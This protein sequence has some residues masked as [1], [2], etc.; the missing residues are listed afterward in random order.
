MTLQSFGASPAGHDDRIIYLLPGKD[1]DLGYIAK[2][3]RHFGYKIEI[4]DDLSGYGNIV[5]P[6]I[7]IVYSDLSG[8]DIERLTP[9][10]QNTHGGLIVISPRDD[11]DARLAAV[12]LGASGYFTDTSDILKIIEK[13]EQY[14]SRRAAMPAWRVLVV[15]DNAI[16]AELYGN[17]LKQAGMNIAI[18]TNTRAAI[19]F[20]GDN[21]V[22]II[23]ID[24]L[25]PDCNGDELAALIRQQDRYISLPLVF[26]SAREDIEEMLIGRDLGIDE[27]LKKPFSPERLVSVIASRALRAAELRSYMVRDSFTGLLNHAYFLEQ[28]DLELMNARRHGKQTAYAII[29]ID[30]FK[31]V[32]DTYGHS[33]GDQVLK[34]LSRLMQQRLRRTDI[35]GRC[36]GEEFGI[37][38]P[39]CGIDDARRMIE[40]LRLAFEQMTFPSGNSKINATFSAGIVQADSPSSLDKIVN[41]ADSALYQAKTQGRNRVVVAGL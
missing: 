13:I 28:F 27:F 16:L 11:F 30:H 19:E 12:R 15:D 18:V 5:G 41:A 9:L 24:Y 21:P 14:F 7:S 8:R 39:G 37:I 4:L 17:M 22:D 25:M 6:H 10:R 29:D 32:N 33:A 35:I 38:M 1:G 34:G 36:G 2:Q 40:N 20:L 23:L 31:K 26:M 3:L